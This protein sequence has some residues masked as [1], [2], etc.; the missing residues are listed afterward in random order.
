MA[1]C[2]VYILASRRNG[3]LYIGVTSDMARRLSEHRAGTAGSFTKR[4]AVTLLVYCE[5]HDDIRTA[6]QREK[7]LK[8]WPRAWKLKLIEDANPDWR[9]LSGDLDG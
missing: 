2:Y 4:Y 1:R 6:I 8:K 3:T 9:D 7:S 5:T